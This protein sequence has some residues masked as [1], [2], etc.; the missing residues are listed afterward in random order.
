MPFS[1]PTLQF[2]LPFIPCPL[3]IIPFPPPDQSSSAQ[4]IPHH[5]SAR[6]IIF[7]SLF[8]DRA[9]Q[10]S[11]LSQASPSL[12]QFIVPS[13]AHLPKHILSS[14]STSLTIIL[15]LTFPHISSAQPNL[16]RCQLHSSSGHH[17]PTSLPLPF[18][19]P[20]ALCRTPNTASQPH[21]TFE[22]DQCLRF[23]SARLALTLSSTTLFCGGESPSR[24]ADPATSPNQNRRPTTSSS[25]HSL[26]DPIFG[27][28]RAATSITFLRAMALQRWT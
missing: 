8:L 19:D 16:H 5:K 26:L 12:P 9:L 11:A 17:Y 6:P 22:L 25:A 15:V 2:P 7:N 24:S 14:S 21:V 10:A 18:L 27:D 23:P 28:G 13:L 1:I 20:T 4:P 3:S